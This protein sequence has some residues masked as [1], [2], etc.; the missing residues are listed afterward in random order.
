MACYNPIS[1]Y[2]CVDRK[3][4]IN[5]KIVGRG[6]SSCYSSLWPVHW[7]SFEPFQD[8]GGEVYA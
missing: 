1:G 6:W 7:L 2:I 3:F 4:R 8:V 5:N